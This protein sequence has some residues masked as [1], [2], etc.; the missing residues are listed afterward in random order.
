[1]GLDQ[2]RRLE[3]LE[4]ENNHLKEIVADL[5]LNNS[6]FKEVIEGKF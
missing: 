1:M 6:I 2:M 5:S 3:K 4:Q